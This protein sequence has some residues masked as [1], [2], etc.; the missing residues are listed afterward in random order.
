MKTFLP[1]FGFLTIV[2]LIA[3]LFFANV[4]FGQTLTSDQDDYAP[5]TTATFTGSGFFPG[6]TVS[7]VVRH[8]DETPDTGE[9]HSSWTVVADENGNFVTT[10][11]VCEDDCLGSTL[12]ATADGQTSGL[13]AEAVFTDA[14]QVGTVIVGAQ[15]TTPVCPGSS[16]TYTVTLTRSGT[17]GGGFSATLTISGLPTGAGAGTFSPNP[18]VFGGSDTSK[19]SILTVP[20]TAGTILSGSTIFTV[21]ATPPAGGVTGTGTLLVDNVLPVITC[22]ANITITCSAST[23]PSNTGT[24]TATDN[25]GGTI[26]VTSTDVDVAGCGGSHVITRTWKATDIAGNFSTC[27]QTIT[28]SPA[29]LPT[30]T[31]PAAT[32]VVC[33]SIPAPSSISF[34]NGLSGGCL[35]SGTSNPSTFTTT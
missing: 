15:S 3:N 12:R 33:G 23:N 19:T 9:D 13:H 34:S 2:F 22:P 7:M 26:T 27:V 6:E 28:V 29:T 1:K 32:T 11:H 21:K 31:A 25:C 16:V 14:A 30:M 17:G 5:G 4:S 20:T 18:V 10:W 24:A 8:A 35:I